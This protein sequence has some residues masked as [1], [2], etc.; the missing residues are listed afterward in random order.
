MGSLI[1][2]PPQFAK[3]AMVSITVQ[4]QTTPGQQSQVP[5]AVL[6]NAGVP[7]AAATL[8]TKTVQ[9]ETQ[10]FVFD[11]VIGL[12]HDQRLVKTQH[13]VQTGADISSH[14]YLMPAH[15]ALYVGMS[16]AIAAYKPGMWV[17]NPSKSVSAYQQMIALQAARVPLVV[18]TRLRTYNNMLIVCVA[19]H[20]DHKTIKGLKM[21]VELEQIFTASTGPAAVSTRSND[22]NSTGLGPVN[23]QPVPPTTQKQ[24]A[25]AAGGASTGDSPAYSSYSGPQVV[26]QTSLSQQAGN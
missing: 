25:V 6:G 2:T 14:A 17:G 8:T 9:L 24:F 11:A 23:P 7:F 13:P 20:E 19:P 26:T 4:S 10:T 16:D 12:E 18:T 3:P 1:W 21:R 5:N 15:L 22:T